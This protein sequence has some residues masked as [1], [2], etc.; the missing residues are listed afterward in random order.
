M[1]GKRRAEK[2]KRLR[3]LH[4]SD[5]RLA[6]ARKRRKARE[7]A[8]VPDAAVGMPDVSPQ[9]VMVEA[10]SEAASVADIVEEMAPVEEKGQESFDWDAFGVGESAEEVS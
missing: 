4:G 8:E 7:S 10:V 1:G 3:K 6:R 2:K 5:R 9:K